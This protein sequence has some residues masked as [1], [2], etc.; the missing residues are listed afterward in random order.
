MST[1]NA[2][3]DHLNTLGRRARR[4]STRNLQ[5]ARR[6]TNNMLDDDE[7]QQHA[8]VAA[9]LA[10]AES[11]GDPDRWNEFD[12]EQQ[13]LLQCTLKH[14]R[15]AILGSASEFI[16][17]HQ[18]NAVRKSGACN[19]ALCWDAWKSGVEKSPSAKHKAEPQPMAGE[20]WANDAFDAGP[21]E[22][23]TEGLLW[24]LANVLK[25]QEVVWLVRRYR[26]N[27]QQDTLAKELCAKDARY[28]DETGYDRAIN[29]IN[30]TIHRAKKRAQRTLG[31]KWQALALEAA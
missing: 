13:S 22:Y 28:Q 3:E 17:I 21:S 10:F 2:L 29:Y 19:A 6:G 15:A 8:L 24:A 27:V 4:I 20:Y 16:D 5:W 26:D 25:P 7:W 18:R 31:T 11:G 30:V 12:W 9:Y 1:P 14:L 23:T